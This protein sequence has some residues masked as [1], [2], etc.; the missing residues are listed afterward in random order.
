M[1]KNIT[2]VIYTDNPYDFN[3]E[4]IRQSLINSRGNEDPS[5]SDCW[6]E[7]YCQC[8]WEWEDVSEEAKQDK[9]YYII[10]GTLGLWNGNF[11]GSCL[12]RGNLLDAIRKCLEDYNRIYMYNKKLYI[13]ATHHDGTNSFII[14]KLTEKGV[15]YLNKYEWEMYDAELNQ[16]LFKDSHYSRHVDYFSRLYGWYENK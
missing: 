14:K 10:V 6:D 4:E 2:K 9:G 16:R 15:E 8:E 11:K 5:D 7:W 1:K 13:E 12:I 3:E